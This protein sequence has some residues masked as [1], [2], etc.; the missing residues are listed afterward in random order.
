MSSLAEVTKDVKSAMAKAVENSKREFATIRSGKASIGL[1]DSIK[2]DAY[3]QM[4]PL[5][6]VG[7]VGAPEARMLTV[8]PWDKG[9]IGPIEKA[10]Q[11]SDLGLNPANDGTIIRIPMP[12]LT[13]DRRKELV[14][15]VH[16]L[17]EDGKIAIRHARHEAM[18]QIKAVEHVSDDEKKHA[19][20]DVQ[21]LHDDFV[22][23]VDT[24]VKHKEE[25]I[26]EV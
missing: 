3:G 22:G 5:S 7:S 20:K 23:Q 17:A 18:T 26:M 15:V 4:M 2:V 16:K 19:E 10:I 14:K 21:K 9:L 12:Q 25:E 1:L 6:Q 24:M 13:E 8:Q 11:N